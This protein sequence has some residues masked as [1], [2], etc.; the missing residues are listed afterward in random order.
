MVFDLKVRV[1]RPLDELAAVPLSDRWQARGG[2]LG[3]RPLTKLACYRRDRL[4]VDLLT[5]RDRAGVWNP[6]TRGHLGGAPVYSSTGLPRTEDLLVSL[7][8]EEV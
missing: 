7:W 1:R 3:G 8:C 6:V 2:A 5:G 4:R